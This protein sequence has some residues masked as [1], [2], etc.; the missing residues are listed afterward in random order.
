MVIGFFGDPNSISDFNPFLEGNPYLAL[1][2]E[3]N[4]EEGSWWGK[5]DIRIEQEFPG[6]AG[7]HKSSAFIV[8]DNFTNLL[9]DDWGVLRQTG[10]PQV[11]TVDPAGIPTSSCEARIGDASRYEIRVGLRYEF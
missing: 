7:G 6:F 5:M 10:F 11:C 1:G 2:A 4:G 9:N 8:V 3:R